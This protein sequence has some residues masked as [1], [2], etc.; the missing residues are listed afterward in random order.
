[1]MVLLC[2]TLNFSFISDFIWAFSPLFLVSLANA[3]KILFILS[4]YQLLVSLIS[5]FYLVYLFPLF[6]YFHPSTNFGLFFVVVVVSV[7]LVI[8]LNYSRFLF[9]FLKQ[10]CIAMNYPLWTAFV[11]SHRFQGFFLYSQFLLFQGTFLFL[12]WPIGRS[13][14]CCFIFT[15]L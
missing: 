7:L 6:S 13:V 8:K 1:M 12:H 2:I 11:V 15:Y 10:A 9:C 5:V 3:L 14:A 4:K